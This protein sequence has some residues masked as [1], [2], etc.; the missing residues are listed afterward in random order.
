MQ[1]PIT[2]EAETERRLKS[3]NTQIV[4]EV[5]SGFGR[6]LTNG[7]KPEVDATVDGA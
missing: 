7:R 6:D 3:G 5:P 2:S 1:P 4:V